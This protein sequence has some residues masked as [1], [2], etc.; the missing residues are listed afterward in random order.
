MKYIVYITI[1]TETDKIYIG[2][3]KTETDKFDGYIGNGVNIFKSSTITNPKTHFQSAVKKYGFDKFKRYTLAEFDNETDALQLEQLLVT[4]N[5]IDR[6]DT[7]NM[8]E[9]GQ[10]IHKRY[11]PIYQFDLSGNLIN[12]FNSIQEASIKTNIHELNI[13]SAYKNRKS[14][15]NYYWAT[16]EKID[17]NDYKLVISS[18]LV[19][20]FNL[21][22]EVVKTYNS[23]SEA[24]KDWD[25]SVEQI[26]NA[27][28][29]MT[30]INKHYFSY[31]PNISL[32]VDSNQIIHKYELN[33]NYILSK[34]LLECSNEE[35]LDINKLFKAANQGLALGGF[36]WNINKEDKMHDL[37]SR[38]GIG[39]PKKV[40]RYD[41]EGNLLEVFETVT[42]CKQIY[43]NVR[44]VLNGQLPKTKGYIF[45]YIE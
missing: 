9:G 38:Q 21:N 24:G 42:Q 14:C 7:Y 33:G 11:V 41:D 25:C 36:Q 8:V 30:K 27:I 4:N 40:G 19:Y 28:Y 20:C 6:V 1:N 22:L 29:K 17:I 2:V 43:T 32:K 26:K 39:S 3:H 15:N 12:S 16:N 10:E 37:T 34:S 13:I 35:H 5:F 44:K 23:L 31:N 18:K 45:K